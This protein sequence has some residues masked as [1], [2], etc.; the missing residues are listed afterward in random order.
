[1]LDVRQDGSLESARAVSG[2]PLLRQ[3]AL[4]S[5]Q[6]SQFECRGC[7]EAVTSY[8][9]VYT[10]E[11]GATRYCTTISD[12]ANNEPEGSRPQASQSQNHVTVFDNPVGTCD[13]SADVHGKVRS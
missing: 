13:M 5:A 12:I 6:Q 9:V 3:A 4:D 1:M 11:L 2:P 7:G 10:F 8:Q